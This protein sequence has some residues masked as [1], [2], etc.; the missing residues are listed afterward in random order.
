MDLTKHFKELQRLSATLKK[1]N[2]P[3]KPLRV[4]R[5]KPRILSPAPDVCVGLPVQLILARPSG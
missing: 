3:K 5:W 2:A 4:L 1:L